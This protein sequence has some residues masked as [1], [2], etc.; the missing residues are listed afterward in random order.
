MTICYYNNIL[1]WFDPVISISRKDGRLFNNKT[2]WVA[3][4]SHTENSEKLRRKYTY[5]SNDFTSDYETESTIKLWVSFLCVKDA[6]N[7][8]VKNQVSGGFCKLWVS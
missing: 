7:F 8:L 6:H 5:L 3:G 1:A 2:D 4:L